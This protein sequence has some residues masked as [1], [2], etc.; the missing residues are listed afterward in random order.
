MPTLPFEFL[1]PGPVPEYPIP[2]EICALQG[3]CYEL[4]AGLFVLGPALPASI[5]PVSIGS[6]HARSTQS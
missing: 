6:L 3:V 2:K 4:D 5:P 1:L